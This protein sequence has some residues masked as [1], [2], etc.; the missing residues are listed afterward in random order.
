MILEGDILA[1]KTRKKDL[2]EAL[3]NYKVDLALGAER[4][5]RKIGKFYCHKP[6]NQT[7]GKKRKY[8]VDAVK[9]L[10]QA[11]EEKCGI[12][13]S[14]LG[15]IYENQVK[16]SLWHSVVDE[17]EKRSL[18]QNQRAKRAMQFYFKSAKL[19]SANR[20]NDCGT[21]FDLGYASMD[22]DL[23]LCCQMFSKLVRERFFSKRLQSL[24]TL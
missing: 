19:D 22:V 6:F 1:E 4:S 9:F 3:S 7:N 20:Y 24:V 12:A 10:N 18:T 5:S 23:G 13:A 8:L 16:D 11:V 14:Y 2:R 21:C 17:F 15:V